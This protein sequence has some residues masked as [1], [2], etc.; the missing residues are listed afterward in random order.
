MTGY[1]F[2]FPCHQ[3]HQAVNRAGSDIAE[4]TIASL[5]TGRC[6]FT[7]FT[8]RNV[9]SQLSTVRVEPTLVV[10]HEQR[11]RLVTCL[12]HFELCGDGFLAVDRGNTCLCAHN[13]D[14]CM[15]RCVGC[16]ADDIELLLVQEFPL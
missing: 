5:I 4:P 13:R 8:G 3:H 11:T 9:V 6:H 2:Y 12:D 15:I 1:A 7:Y 16:N 14:L 10:Q